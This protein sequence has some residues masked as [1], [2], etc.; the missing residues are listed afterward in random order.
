[1]KLFLK[2]RRPSKSE[3]MRYREKG[4]WAEYKKWGVRTF[5]FENKE[6]AIQEGVAITEAI[7]KWKI[8]SRNAYKFLNIKM[9]YGC[10]WKKELI[11]DLSRKDLVK[12]VGFNVK[13]YYAP[14]GSP[15]YKA[16][17]NFFIPCIRKRD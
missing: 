9:P 17:A 7:T 10:I 16:H 1:M 2:V 5:E 6:D 12:P 8:S 13:T 15:R 4:E 14:D 3:I 11:K